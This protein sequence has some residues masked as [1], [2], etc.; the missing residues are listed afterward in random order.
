MGRR[1][2]GVWAA[3]GNGLH[4]GEARLLVAL[5]VLVVAHLGNGCGGEPS[6]AA[7][8]AKW[9]AAGIESYSYNV[10]GGNPWTYPD[11]DPGPHRVVVNEGG[12][13]GSDQWHGVPKRI[14]EMFDYLGTL[15]VDHLE[16]DYHDEL[17]Y[18]TR[19]EAD[20]N[21]DWTDDEFVFTISDF[22]ETDL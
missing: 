22:S 18:P 3:N 6:L 8:R 14:D 10:S 17:G 5:A 2:V 16:V 7:S 4:R 1:P 13:I 11:S 20:P 21:E 15:D 12:V 9:E 19:I